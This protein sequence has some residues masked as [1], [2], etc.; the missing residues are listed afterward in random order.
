MALVIHC[1]CGYI[2]RGE[3]EDE[4]VSEAQKHIQ[5]AH[6]ELAGKVSRD[7]LIAMAEEQ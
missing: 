4:L 5:D 7:D 2:S 6:P 3:S 1:D